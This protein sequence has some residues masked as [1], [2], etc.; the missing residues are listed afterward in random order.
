MELISKKSIKFKTAKISPRNLVIG[1]AVIHLF[2]RNRTIFLH[3]KVD[4]QKYITLSVK[5]GFTFFPFSKLTENSPT[6]YG[7]F[8]GQYFSSRYSSPIHNSYL[9]VKLALISCNYMP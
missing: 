9:S 3:K 1:F 7:V 6:L 2:L 8:K 4:L 5:L